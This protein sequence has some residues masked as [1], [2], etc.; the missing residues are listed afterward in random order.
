L[1]TNFSGVYVYNDYTFTAGG[2]ATLISPTPGT[3]FAD[4]SETFTWA[5]VPGAT[6]YALYLGSTGVGSANIYNSKAITTTTV[7]ANYLPVDG[8]T[9]YARL[10]TNFSGVYVYTDS[11]FTAK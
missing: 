2:G 4:T 11:T 8:E 9:I 1:W 7:T 5:S 6:G 10:W 3:I